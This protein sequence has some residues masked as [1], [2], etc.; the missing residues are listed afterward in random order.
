M[1]SIFIYFWVRIELASPPCT[2]ARKHFNL[3][4][5]SFT[6][7]L[8]LGNVIRILWNTITVH[9]AVSSASQRLRSCNWRFVFAAMFS[10]FHSNWVYSTSITHLSFLTII[11]LKKSIHL[12][13]KKEYAN[14]SMLLMR[15]KF[16]N[17]MNRSDTRI[18][19]MFCA[20]YDSAN[21]K[22]VNQPKRGERI[23][24]KK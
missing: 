18:S 3:F 9:N 6:W 17:L 23:Q 5:N 8:F 20:A 22:D 11:S 7:F 14:W 4:K 2:H 10:S 19:I 24:R 13:A 16:W 12:L 15:Q 21:R 1:N